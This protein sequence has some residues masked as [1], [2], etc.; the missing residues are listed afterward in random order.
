MRL[1]VRVSLATS[2]FL[3]TLALIAFD[4]PPVTS[5]PFVPRTSL[6]SKYIRTVFAMSDQPDPSSVSGAALIASTTPKNAN[7]SSSQS[8]LASSSQKTPIVDPITQVA[9]YIV[10]EYPCSYQKTINGTLYAGSKALYFVGYDTA[11]TKSFFA[12]LTSSTNNKQEINIPWEG[13]RKVEKDGTGSIQVLCMEQP[14]NDNESTSMQKEEYVFTNIH[15][16]DRVWALL[17]SLHNDSLMGRPPSLRRTSVLNVHHTQSCREATTPENDSSPAMR[18]QRRRNSDPLLTSTIRTLDESAIQELEEAGQESEKGDTNKPDDMMALS[19][20]DDD[21][22]P[23]SKTETKVPS[24]RTMSTSSVN[25]TASA[26]SAV[27]TFLSS[28]GLDI[29]TIEKNFA[30]KLTLQPIQCTYSNKLNLKG[31][32]YVGK[33]GIYFQGQKSIWSWFDAG[34]VLLKWDTIAR[35]KIIDGT[36]STGSTSG[37]TSG[38]SSEQTIARSIGIRVLTKDDRDHRFIQ[39][40]DADQ[41]WVKL[42]ALHNESLTNKK[43]ERPRSSPRSEK[44]L[45]ILRTNSDPN[46]ASEAEP[47]PTGAKL[48][49]SVAQG[50]ARTTAA[51][52]AGKSSTSDAAGKAEGNFDDEKDW[53]DLLKN[54]YS[55]QVI[56]EH[57]LN[58]SIDKFVELFFQDDA[59]Y[60]IGKFLESRGDSNLST[61]KWEPDGTSV[62][63]TRMVRYTHPVNAPMAPPQADARKEQKMRRYGHRG[64]CV[65]TETNVDDV[66]MTDC[67]HVVDRV[68]AE[69][70]GDDQVAVF[71]EFHVQFVK[72]TMFKSIISKTTSSECTSVFQAM[73]KYMSEALG[74]VSAV[75]KEE[76]SAAPVPVAAPVAAPSPLLHM[77]TSRGRDIL[78]FG[79]LL[80]QVWIVRE[81]RETRVVLGIVQAAVVNTCEAPR[82]YSEYDS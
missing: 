24:Q 72:S 39:M 63:Q 40:N 4:V 32:L 20:T 19:A 46:L 76:V 34:D 11:P 52:A 58:C 47:T 13:I 61:S 71:M 35:I 29:A 51:S 66:P 73:A 31:R 42:V 53:N 80:M 21:T 7:S 10:G 25:S 17:I 18:R 33:G 30:G 70:R 43:Q 9:G 59:E 75:T 74:D 27:D 62:N 28:A 49:A 48:A 60:S 79:V 77:I 23:A 65:W 78:L 37:T 68:R 12:T 5:K 55:S 15:A 81:L 26:P 14:S 36:A 56:K 16:P 41:V 64:V 50:G 57:I 45:S 44:R 82:L 69:P 1:V 3:L 54:P 8:A 6:F 2:T 67:F 22:T 38:Q